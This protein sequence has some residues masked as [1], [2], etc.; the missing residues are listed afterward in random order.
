MPAKT[1]LVLTPHLRILAGF[2]SISLL[3]A[4][5]ASS[6]AFADLA[7]SANDNKLVLVN[8]VPTVVASPRPDT[9]TII[10]LSAK[11][12]R[13]LNELNVATSVVG[14]PLSVAITPDESLVL[15]PGAMRIDPSDP[16][17]QIPDNKLSVIDLRANPPSVVVELNAGLGAAG[18]SINREGTLALV[19]NRSDGSVSVFKIDGHTVRKIDTVQIGP[20]D[21]GV[22]H[23]AISPNGRTALVTRDGDNMISVLSINGDRVEYTKRDFG[24]GLKPYGIVISADG[25]TAIVAHLGIGRGDNDTISLIDL[26]LN[27]PRV[28]DT[29]TV[30][31]TPEGITISPDGKLVAVVTMNGSNKAKESPFYSPFGRLLLFRLNRGGLKLIVDAHIGIWPQGA[32]FSADGKTLL[33]QSMDERNIMVFSIDDNYRLK[34]TGQRIPL[35]GGGAALRT[36]DRPVK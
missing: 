33:V 20:P 5:G 17:R 22:S 12:P 11:P 24:V 29:Y 6:T 1:G 30:G 7:V 19:A 9:V 14:P 36:A 26:T 28:T 3:V 13:I 18:L 25:Q 23:V 35:Q 2:A 34:D 10:D 15:V 21:S 16:T 32:A 4:A 27:P 31:Q 8:G